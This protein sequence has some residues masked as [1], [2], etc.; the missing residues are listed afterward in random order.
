MQMI[1]Q[2]RDKNVKVVVNNQEN[3]QISIRNTDLNLLKNRNQRSKN[4]QMFQITPYTGKCAS[5][6][7]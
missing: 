7:H 4:F 5:C 1:F 2:N 3:K 6:G